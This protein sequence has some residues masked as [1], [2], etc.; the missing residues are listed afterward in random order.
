MERKMR[1][2]KISLLVFFLSITISAQSRHLGHNEK[3][4]HNPFL[5][6]TTDSTYLDFKQEIISIINKVGV[7]QIE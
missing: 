7:K 5:T 3:I 1:T 2:L 6:H 4:L